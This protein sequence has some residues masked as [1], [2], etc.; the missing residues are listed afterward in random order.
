MPLIQQDRD[1]RRFRRLIWAGTVLTL[2]VL[3]YNVFQESFLSDIESYIRRR[4]YYEQV[5]SKKGLSLHEGQ[6]WRQKE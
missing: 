4:L 3:F 6:H 2:L 1:T 5:I